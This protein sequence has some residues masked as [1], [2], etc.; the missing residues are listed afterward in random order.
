VGIFNPLLDQ[1][2][3]EVWW[4][5]GEIAGGWL[6]FGG[7][8]LRYGVCALCALLLLERFGMEALLGGLRKLH[9]PAILVTQI[10]LMT[11]YLFVLVQEVSQLL[12]AYRLRSGGRN[13]RISEAGPLLGGMLL[14]TL[15]RASE[16]QHAMELRGFQGVLTPKSGATWKWRD[17]ALLLVVCCWVVFAHVLT[18]SAFAG[19]L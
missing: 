4:L 9:V 2:L 18:G 10:A 17:T 1:A 5:P 11:R 8:L 19:L 7:I 3:V 12:D 13:P 15:D 6:S 16:I 14:R